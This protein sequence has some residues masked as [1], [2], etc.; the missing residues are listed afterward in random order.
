VSGDAGMTRGFEA[1]DAGLC[2]TSVK[3]TGS[4]AAN[5]LA[6]GYGDDILAGGNGADVL[7][8]GMGAD[9]FLFA[10]RGGVDHITDFSLGQDHFGLQGIGASQ[11]SWTEAGG[12]TRVDLGSTVVMLDG[13]V[14]LNLS[15]FLFF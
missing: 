14:G 13:V 5:S 3:L 11:V 6:G 15:D 8:G 7:T 2:L 12:D 10:A 4:D 1:V 9:T